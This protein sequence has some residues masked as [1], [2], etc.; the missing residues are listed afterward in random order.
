[1]TA[2]AAAMAM[3]EPSIF[4]ITSPVVA[5][6]YFEVVGLIKQITMLSE[7]ELFIFISL[8]IWSI[9]YFRNNKECIK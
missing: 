1:M 8:L 5:M 3:N 6:S 9:I 7:Y 2:I 4:P